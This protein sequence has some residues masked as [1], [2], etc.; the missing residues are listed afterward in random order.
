MVHYNQ[1]TTSLC[2][3][4]RRR[5][6]MGMKDMIMTRVITINK[7]IS[8]MKREMI[9]IITETVKVLKTEDKDI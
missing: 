5:V 6:T 2:N 7:I 4:N 9:D 8:Q 1:E 3:D